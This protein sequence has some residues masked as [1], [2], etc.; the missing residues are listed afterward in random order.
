M[1]IKAYE[2]NVSLSFPSEADAIAFVNRRSWRNGA[3]LKR[4]GV[5]AVEVRDYRKESGDEDE[6]R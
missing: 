4:I 3:T 5:T 2:V 6:S 1:S